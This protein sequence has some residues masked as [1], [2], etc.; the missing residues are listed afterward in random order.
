MTYA[1]TNATLKALAVQTHSNHIF[2]SF[3][4]ASRST[5]WE[6][7]N[8][9]MTKFSFTGEI[10][11]YGQPLSQVS[12][13]V[14]RGKDPRTGGQLAEHTGVYDPARG[15]DATVQYTHYIYKDTGDQFIVDRAKQ[16][17]SYEA[18]NDGTMSVFDLCADMLRPLDE[19]EEATPRLLALS[20]TYYDGTA[21]TGLGFGQIGSYGVPVRTE[22]LMVQQA[23]SPPGRA[24]P[25]RA[26]RNRT[27]A[28]AWMWFTSGLVR[29]AWPLNTLLMA[30]S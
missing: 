23:G 4:L 8:D 19:W 1:T 25:Y 3:G 18:E 24:V 26:S 6:R 27:P 11:A 22:T 2:F 28:S 16:A 17:R 10:D 30:T 12:I 13:A 21:F 9:P 14:P 29:N 7:G 15:Y 20:S 5:T